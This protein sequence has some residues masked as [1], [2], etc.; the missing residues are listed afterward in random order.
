MPTAKELKLPLQ[1]RP[2]QKAKEKGFDRVHMV[3]NY[4]EVVPVLKEDDDWSIT[5]IIAKI[6]KLTSLFSF[7]DF[8]FYL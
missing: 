6:K 1:K 5:L 2:K 4:K 3:L 8:F 7:V